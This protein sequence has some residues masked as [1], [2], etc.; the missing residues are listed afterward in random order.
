MV[1]SFMFG[2]SAANNLGFG[3]DLAGT[4]KLL[5]NDNAKEGMM[6]CLVKSNTAPHKYRVV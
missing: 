6:A 5:A 2:V 3:L 1:S 4:A